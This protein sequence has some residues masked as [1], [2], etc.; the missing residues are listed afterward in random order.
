MEVE[1]VPGLSNHIIRVGQVKFPVLDLV[2]VPRP[3][4]GIPGSVEPKF[5]F[6]LVEP[7]F[8]VR[9]GVVHRSP[10]PGPDHPGRQGPTRPRGP[11]RPP[12]R[13][14]AGEKAA[15]GDPQRCP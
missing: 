8:M 7:F 13:R 6:L 12:A 2:V 5:P 15:V 14:P 10:P 9:Y 1:V 3:G 4:Q 11:Q